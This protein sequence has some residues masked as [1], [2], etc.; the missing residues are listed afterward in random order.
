MTIPILFQQN[1][2]GITPYAI[3]TS[4]II[5]IFYVFASFGIHEYKRT[6]GVSPCFHESSVATLL[7]VL[8]GSFLK[9]FTGKSVVF[10]KNLFFYLVLPPVIFS[11]GIILEIIILTLLIQ[12][13]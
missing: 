3:P 1:N 8:V 12:L 9:I 4:I 6:I 7:G 13:Y 5:I 2:D 11:A 10:D